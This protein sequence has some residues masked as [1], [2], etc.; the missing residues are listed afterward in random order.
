MQL[1]ELVQLKL[2]GA[3]ES[4]LADLISEAAAIKAAEMEGPNSPMYERLWEKFEE[5]LWE[6]LENAG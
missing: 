5:E 3:S 6:D 2:Q 4:E 1:A